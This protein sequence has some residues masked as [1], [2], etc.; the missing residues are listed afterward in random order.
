MASDR[1]DL[2]QIGRELDRV[3]DRLRIVGASIGNLRERIENLEKKNAE[4]HELYLR[5]RVADGGD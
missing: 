1:L 5:L 3:R 4:D 2:E